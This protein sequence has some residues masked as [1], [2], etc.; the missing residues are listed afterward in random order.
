MGATS[1]AVRNGLMFRPGLA[2]EAKQLKPKIAGKPGVRPGE[3]GSIQSTA[4]KSGNVEKGDDRSN[5]RDV[6]VVYNEVRVAERGQLNTPEAGTWV[7]LKPGYR[8]FDKGYPE[9]LIV[10][11][12]GQIVSN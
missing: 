6:F 9:K 2:G 1:C 12:E 5:G 11:R 7:P 4:F 10:E 3:S 8:V